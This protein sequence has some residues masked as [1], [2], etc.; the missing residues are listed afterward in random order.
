MM[1]DIY[2]TANLGTNL[3]VSLVLGGVICGL[4]QTFGGEWY[5]KTIEDMD[6]TCYGAACFRQ[7]FVVNQSLIC[8]SFVLLITLKQRIREKR[9][10]RRKGVQDMTYLDHL[11]E[12]DFMT[13]RAAKENLFA[14][15]QVTDQWLDGHVVY[16]SEHAQQVLKGEIEMTQRKKE[17]DT[18][19]DTRLSSLQSTAEWTDN[20]DS[21]TSGLVFGGVIAK[22]V[23]QE[24]I[25]EE[26]KRNDSETKEEVHWLEQEEDV[27]LDSSSEDGRDLIGDYLDSM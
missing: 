18:S 13:S 21:D 5:A 2:G 17:R 23:F 16:G 19:S 11:A 6:V 25:P 26:E 8:M 9:D 1:A 7:L 14:E 10:V 22:W 20:A 15:K 12:R 27:L 24:K 3:G 4:L